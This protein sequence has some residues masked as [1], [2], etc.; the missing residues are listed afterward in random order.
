MTQRS[1]DPTPIKSPVQR[2][3]KALAGCA[4]VPV[5][6]GE[7]WM[8]TPFLEKA[9]FSDTLENHF[10]LASGLG[11]DMVCLPVADDSGHKPDLG[12][13]YFE[14]DD[15]KKIPDAPALFTAAVVDGPFQELV[16]RIGLTPLLTEWIQEPEDTLALFQNEQKNT[17]SLIRRCLDQTGVHAIVLTDDFAMEQGPMISPKDIDT[18]CTP[19]YRQAAESVHGAGGQLFLHSC[20]KITSLIPLFTTWQIDGLA[21]VQHQINDLDTFRQQMPCCTIMA[22]IDAPLLEQHTAP[23]HFSDFIDTIA[24]LAAQGGLILCSACGL[25]GADHLDAIK[26]IYRRVDGIK[27]TH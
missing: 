11:Q 24:K 10:R 26:A 9:G 23:A 13:R 14:P 6:K 19:F 22:G 4:V 21:A 18:L 17:L 2:I 25:Y 16:N 3:R 8:G 7:I 12:Y 20:G 1:T 15:L 5:P 27:T